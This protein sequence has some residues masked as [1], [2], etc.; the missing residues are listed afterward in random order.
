MAE[1]L[2]PVVKLLLARME[3]HPE[4]FE[5]EYLM[6]AL[7]PIDGS[8]RWHGAIRAVNANGTTEDK[9]ALNAKLNSIRMAQTH[10]WVMDELCNGD[11]RRRKQEEEHEYERNLMQQSQLKALG[12]QQQVGL[13]VSMPSRHPTLT[14]TINQIKKVISK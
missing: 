10:E 6:S 2:H 4:E 1:I 7:S 13:G 5:D 14:D 8:G 11:E 12:L 9:V 3:S